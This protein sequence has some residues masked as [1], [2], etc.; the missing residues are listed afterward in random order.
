MARKIKAASRTPVQYVVDIDDNR[1]DPEP[2]WVEFIPLSG[3]EMRDVERDIGKLSKFKK[4]KEPNFMAESQEKVEK[5]ITE[6]VTRVGN[7]DITDADGKV[8]TATDG[9]SMIR[10]AMIAGATERDRV[11]NNVFYAMQDTA[12]L[13]EG[14]LGKYRS[15]SDSSSPETKRSGSGAASD[16]DE[17]TRAQSPGW[18]PIVAPIATATE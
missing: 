17:K 15:R 5:L 3:A 1:D 6:K 12:T 14:L 18:S 7:Y 8:I 4:N 10:V 11:L 13:E 9:A 16:A 2:F